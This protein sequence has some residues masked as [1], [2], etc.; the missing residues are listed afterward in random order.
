MILYHVMYIDRGYM[1]EMY[2]RQRKKAL[3]AKSN[4]SGS[5]KVKMSRNEHNKVKNDLDKFGYKITNNSK[6]AFL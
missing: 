5:L 1:M 4:I 2:R 3:E 6:E